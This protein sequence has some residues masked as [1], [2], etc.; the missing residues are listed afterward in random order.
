MC[1]SRNLFSNKELQRWRESLFR[2]RNRGQTHK[3]NQASGENRPGGENVPAYVGSL[4][5]AWR[6]Q[7]FPQ[8]LPV[9]A[10]DIGSTG[11]VAV[12]TGQDVADMLGLNLSQRAVKT[13]SAQ[14][15]KAHE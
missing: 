7:V 12:D 9:D 13:A 1:V 4:G 2:V 3:R 5:G 10:E 14:S 15:R 11:L 6:F 8:C